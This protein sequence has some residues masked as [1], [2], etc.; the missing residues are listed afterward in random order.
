MHVVLAVLNL[1]YVFSKR[2]NYITRLGSERRGPLLARL[3]HL[4][5]VGGVFGAFLGGF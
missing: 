1:L 4:A 3:Q 5:E 2:S